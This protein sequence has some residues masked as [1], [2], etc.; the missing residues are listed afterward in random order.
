MLKAW[1]CESKEELHE[2]DSVFL[3]SSVVRMLIALC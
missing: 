2:E 1:G 3:S